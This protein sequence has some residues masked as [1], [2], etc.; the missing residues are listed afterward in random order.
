MRIQVRGQPLELL[1][2]VFH[3]LPHH[4]LCLLRVAVF[5]GLQNQSVVFD[6]ISH[7]NGL[8][9]MQDGWCQRFS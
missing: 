7:A 3:M 1:Q 9:G 2:V 5:Q 8:G 6:P 4:R